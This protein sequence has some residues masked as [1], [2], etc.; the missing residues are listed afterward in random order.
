MR[1]IEGLRADSLPESVV[2]QGMFDGVHRG[3]QALLDACRCYAD[4]LALPAV[5]LTYE[6]HPSR[7]VRPDAPTPLLTPLPEKLER[8]EALGADATVIA[9]FTPAFSQLTPEE[10]VADMVSAVHPR[11]IVVGY[12]ATFGR[13][14]AGTTDALQQ[15]GESYGFAVEVVPPVEI[16]G[17]PV[18]S[19]RL[20]QTLERGE[21]ELATELLGYHYRMTGI[22]THGDAR[23]R[24][25]GYP[26]ANLEV[27]PEKLIPGDGVYAVGVQ[28]QGARY[29]AVMNIGAR[30][31]FNR[32]HSLEVH[33]ID[34]T[35]DLY[36][37]SITVFFS[38]RLRDSRTFA[39]AG[40]LQQQI[41]HDIVRA[42]MMAL[43]QA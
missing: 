20:R 35:G 11:V 37:K 25:L 32:P 42:R 8:L 13:D 23:G 16:A 5:T 27:T 21:I 7:V 4:A 6:P 34:Y 15:L 31:T 38:T 2:A 26:T 10:F 39:S 17:G 18:S 24:E 43:H 19:T 30:P 29:R 12:R 40:E 22:V 1:I 3:H 14:R 33:L 36:G 41:G 9:E 28:I